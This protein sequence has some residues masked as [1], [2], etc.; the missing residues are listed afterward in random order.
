MFVER[1]TEEQVRE[2]LITYKNCGEDVK[3]EY[4]HGF[5]YYV[6]NYVDRGTR[7][8]SEIIALTDFRFEYEVDADWMRFLYGIFGKIYMD[9]YDEKALKFHK[10][11]FHE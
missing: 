7:K 3:V 2:F 10:E 11:V 1:L 6:D 8:K 4:L 9:Y 5:L